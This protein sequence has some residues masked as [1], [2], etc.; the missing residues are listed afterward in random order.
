MRLAM[1]IDGRTRAAA[2]QNATWWQIEKTINNGT[3]RIRVF[4]DLVNPVTL[5]NTRAI[6]QTDSFRDGEWIGKS[7]SSITIAAAWY[8][9]EDNAE[10]ILEQKPIGEKWNHWDCLK[11]GKL[12]A[13]PVSLAA[14]IGCKYP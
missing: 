14:R 2:Q 7:V 3:D 8:W 11:T 4:V 12:P 6:M 9:C 10:A 5:E 1:T 13:Q